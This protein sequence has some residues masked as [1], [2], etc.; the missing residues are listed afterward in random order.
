MGE[1]VDSFADAGAL[2]MNPLFTLLLFPL[3]ADLNY[4]PPSLLSTRSC[5]CVAVEWR[6]L[7]ETDGAR[8]CDNEAG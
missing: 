2:C 7:E 5:V 6:A 3:E 8:W 4:T 1:V